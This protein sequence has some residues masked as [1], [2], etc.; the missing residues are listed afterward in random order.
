MAAR[1]ALSFNERMAA[2]RHAAGLSLQ[3]VGFELRQLLPKA[4]WVSVATLN[5]LELNT[6]EAKADPFLV[7]CRLHSLIRSMSATE[8][9]EIAA[10]RHDVARPSEGGDDGA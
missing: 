2:A 1:K 3:D 10:S 6:S 8:T 7:V 9:A 4:M 5:R